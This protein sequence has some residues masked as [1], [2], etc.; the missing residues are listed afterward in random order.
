M[1]T[2]PVRSLSTI[3]AEDTTPYTAF[4]LAY[5]WYLTILLGYLCLASS[6][7][8]NFYFPL[9]TLLTKQYHASPQAINLTITIYL[10]IQGIS[11]SIFSLLSDTLGR[12]PVYLLSFSLYAA[13]SVGLAFSGDSYAALLV[14]RALQSAGSSATLSLAYSVVSDYAVHA[15]QGKFLAPMMTATNIGPSIGPPIGGGAIGGG[16]ILATGDPRWA[17]WTLVIFGGSALTLVA[18]S[19]RETNRRIVGNGSV[20]AQGIWRAWWDIIIP[21]SSKSAPSK[22]TSPV[23]NPSKPQP[24]TGRGT[25]ALPNPLV[26]LRLLFQKEAFTILYLA[27]SPYGAWYTVT[28]SIPLIY[29][30]EYH[31]NDLNVGLCY[32]AGG[33]GILAGGFVAGKMMDHNY[34]HVASTLGLTID[35]NQGDNIHDFPI[36]TARSRGS[37]TLVLLTTLGF[38]AYGW[39]V[40]EKTHPALPLVL[41]FGL[42]AGVT[43]LYQ[44]YSALLVD[45]FRDTPGTAGAS[46][47]ICRCAVAAVGVAVLQP[48]VD[49]VGRGWF[50][51]LVGGWNGAGCAVGVWVLRRWGRRW[52]GERVAR[53]EEESGG[54]L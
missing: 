49:V 35:R 20:P 46:N 50:F 5:R 22:A 37:Y 27:A 43:V 38:A 32:L 54:G 48:L 26:P 12:R 8:A 23:T 17:F 21:P 25:F 7:T 2:P 24:P 40:E 45:V 11:P 1:T 16:A 51:T 33:A 47:N 15:E 3:S 28:A 42:G 41:Q 4:S 19:M 29:G 36:E 9:I 31:F 13:A 14:L 44:V 18:I 10:V 6:L 39:A 34:R 53:Q 30:L 52:R